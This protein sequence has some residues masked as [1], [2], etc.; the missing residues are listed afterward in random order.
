[1]AGGGSRGYAG[2]MRW[3]LG[4][5]LAA[6]A[7]SIESLP[8][9]KAQALRER[10]RAAWEEEALWTRDWL[11]DEA[12]A[13]RAEARGPSGRLLA[14]YDDIGALLGE[15]LG[16]ETGRRVA[17]MLREQAGFAADVLTAAR[18]GD[19]AAMGTADGRWR[20][21]AFRLAE[22]LSGVN[23]SWSRDETR[24][25]FNE[26]VTWTQRQVAAQVEEDW[27]T[28]IPYFEGAR[29]HGRRIAD[30]LT[31]GLVEQFPDRF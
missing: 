9:D 6:T 11:K 2:R 10:M 31:N 15:H 29:E 22:L 16:A 13:R 19:K 25:L 12:A 4:M 3:W 7:L 20:E 30:W 1:M 17:S 5:M 21:N 14:A 26:R 27:A 24:A 8:G 18:R 23:P 28:D